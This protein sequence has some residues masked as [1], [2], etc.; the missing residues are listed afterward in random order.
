MSNMRAAH[1]H[2]DL[3]AAVPPPYVALRRRRLTQ[4]LRLRDLFADSCDL[5]LADEDLHRLFGLLRDLLLVLEL[6]REER[7]RLTELCLRVFAALKARV[8]VLKLPQ[9]DPDAS[10][11]LF[12]VHLGKHIRPAGMQLSPR[13]RSR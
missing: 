9:V 4:M 6:A 8:E 13:F 7:E 12:W 1:L 2:A 5:G 10:L 3:H 11:A